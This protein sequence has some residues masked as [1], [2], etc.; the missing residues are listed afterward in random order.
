M[1][2]TAIALTIL[3][4]LAL[5]GCANNN[6]PAP[7]L[8]TEFDGTGV[9]IV[10]EDIEPGTYSQPSPEP[11]CRYAIQNETGKTYSLNSGSAILIANTGDTVTVE[12]CNTYQLN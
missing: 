11:A 4:A 5:T 10:G 9:Y 12:G 1:R 6:T 7:S 8:P 3:T 2:R